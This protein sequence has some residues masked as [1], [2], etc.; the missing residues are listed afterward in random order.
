MDW[1]KNFWNYIKNPEHFVGWFKATFPAAADYKYIANIYYILITIVGLILL[2]ITFRIVRWVFRK[3]IQIFMRIKAFLSKK[4]KKKLPEDDGDDSGTLSKWL[5]KLK[6][7][8]NPEKEP[9][10]EAFHEAAKL[11]KQSFGGNEYMYALPWYLSI[12]DTASGKST[13]LNSLDIKRPF[14]LGPKIDDLGLP[15]TWNYFD[16]GIVLDVRGDV[17]Y[18][19]NKKPSTSKVWL[20]LL[21]Q[22]SY[23]RA[24]RPLDGVIISIS[25]EDLYG[26]NKLSALDMRQKA[27]V[28]YQNL[29]TLQSNLSMRLPVYIVITKTDI[30]PGFD[31]FAKSFNSSNAKN[32]FGWSAPHAIQQPYSPNWINDATDKITSTINDLKLQAFSILRKHEK[33]IDTDAMFVFSEELLTVWENIAA[34]SNQLFGENVYKDSHF[35]RGIYFTGEIDEPK[36]Y[37]A[38]LDL[39]VR[40]Q[41]AKICFARDLFMLKIFRERNIAFPSYEIVQTLWRNLTAGKIGL[42]GGLTTSCL[43]SMWAYHQFQLSKESLAPTLQDMK[44]VLKEVKNLRKNNAKFSNEELDSYYKHLDHFLKTVTENTKFWAVFMPPSWF[45]SF[46]KDAYAAV[47]TAF[48]LILVQSVHQQ[49]Q[50][51]LD[52]LL[53]VPKEP[54]KL[55]DKEKS[56]FEAVDQ[57]LSEKANPVKTKH[58]QSLKEFTDN[59]VLLERITNSYNNFFISRQKDDLFLLMKDLFNYDFT[60]SFK[61]NFYLY[62]WSIQ[63]NAYEKLDLNSY[64]KQIQQNLEKVFDGFVV[65][66]LTQNDNLKKV[67][68]LN[69][70]LDELADVNSYAE[71]SLDDFEN[72]IKTIQD[73]IN[74]SYKTGELA[75]IAEEKFNPGEDY[76]NFLSTLD[77]A[78]LVSKEFVTAQLDRIQTAYATLKTEISGSYSTL[79]ESSVF[80]VNDGGFRANQE[81]IDIKNYLDRFYDESFMTKVEKK[82]LA[83]K[84]IKGKLILWDARHLAN[85]E[86]ML[87]SYYDFMEKGIEDYPQ[88]IR[89]VLEKVSK[90]KLHENLLNLLAVSQYTVSSSIETVGA[91][92]EERFKNQVRSFST[93]WAPL[94]KILTELSS[95]DEIPEQVSELNRFVTEQF[96]GILKGL[97]EIIENEN[98]LKIKGDNFKW[99][100]GEGNPI[101]AAFKVGDSKALESLLDTH[102]RRINKL[103]KDYAKPSVNLLLADFL[104]LQTEERQSLNRWSSILENSLAYEKKQA[105]NSVEKL[106][107]LYLQDLKDIK[108]ETATSTL[109]KIESISDESDYFL[110]QRATTVKALSD[111]VDAIGGYKLLE[112]YQ[113]IANYFND[114]IANKL[115]FSDD[116]SIQDEVDLTSLKEL[117]NL[118]GEKTFSMDEYAAAF[119]AREA[120]A[121]KYIDFFKNL[122]ML[123]RLFKPFAD[124]KSDT[125]TV[126]LQIYFNAIKPRESK[127]ADYLT[128]Q[129]FDFGTGT[130]FDI[131]DNGKKVVWNYGEPVNVTFKLADSAP[132]N[133]FTYSEDETAFTKVSETE[134]VFSYEGQWALF[135]LLSDKA[136]KREKGILQFDIPITGVRGASNLRTFI[137]VTLQST[138]DKEPVTIGEFP[139]L[140]QQAPMLSKKT[141]KIIN[142]LQNTT[143]ANTEKNDEDK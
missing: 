37:T 115:P 121:E 92:P 58:F 4:K 90:M 109:K 42:I 36:V 108:I 27:H 49:V 70:L 61:D 62:N 143:E 128:D 112:Q 137:K 122:D 84:E 48:D 1:I 3:L 5:S 129:E 114:N 31:A 116:P 76:M 97:D 65:Y 16:Y 106:I 43:L 47:G 15:L 25:A 24:R 8:L 123:R 111:R 89:P 107:H 10:E 18:Q 103:A 132:V 53:A 83:T 12:G 134:G 130:P 125:P 33:P 45:S 40:P 22:L 138:D 77:R 9:M 82:G 140:P 67:F 68:S 75:W 52:K 120:A 86:K 50:Q 69:S 127:E 73:V 60:D 30:I 78:Q 7:L 13:L 54:A 6:E 38:N 56:L 110:E 17:I 34:F 96:V 113:K 136:D 126:S 135:K 64:K 55:T 124:G 20:D 23:H 119:K 142:S 21:H 57:K 88:K 72:I 105:G 32:I 101:L 63:T 59:L 131:S 71:V 41:T 29:I 2:Y 100:S 93:A 80:N 99:W 51:R 46:K 104:P 44:M 98:L 28:I 19:E 139:K 11:L 118:M 66:G 39:F 94:K 74:I 26:P 85:A 95:V 81:L 35:L 87:S 102:F 91:N 117:F 141:Q 133:M 79:L 14:G